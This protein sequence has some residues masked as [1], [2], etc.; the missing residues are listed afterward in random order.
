[1]TPTAFRHLVL[2]IR[3]T[4]G[5]EPLVWF[6]DVGG[7]SREDAV[8]LMRASARTLLRAALAESATARS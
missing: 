3:A 7:L 8:T 2:S 4:L 5:V 1:M 6:T